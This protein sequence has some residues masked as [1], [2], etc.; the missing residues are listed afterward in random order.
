MPKV[1]A[2]PLL[3][4]GQ[5]PDAQLTSSLSATRRAISGASSPRPSGSSTRLVPLSC[6][7]YSS[8]Q[9]P[10]SRSND[11]PGSW[12]S[13]G[14]CTSSRCTFLLALVAAVPAAA[15]RPAAWRE[16]RVRGRAAAQQMTRCHHPSPRWLQCRHCRSRCC[17]LGPQRLEAQPAGCGRRRGGR[18]QGTAAQAGAAPSCPRCACLRPSAACHC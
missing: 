11:R 3:S 4:Y 12:L 17:S 9:L 5:P 7:S 1:H 14:P 16:A 18:L 8:R 13:S 2:A 6:P 10:T 15:P